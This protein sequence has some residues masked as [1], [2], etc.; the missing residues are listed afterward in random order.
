MSRKNL[1]LLDK[2][3]PIWIGLTMVFGVMLGKFA[4]KV[5]EIIDSVKIDTVSVPI[6]IGLLWM[7]YPVLAKVNYEKIPQVTRDWKVFTYSIILNWAVG[8]F[9]MYGLAKLFLS[10]YPEYQIG[11]II[12]GIARCIAMVLIWNLLAEGDNE[13]AAILVALNSV[14]QIFLYSVYA[15]FLI[16]THINITMWDIAKNVLIYLGIPLLA[17]FL[18]RF[19]LIRVKDQEWYNNK[20]MPK[21]S[22]TAMIGLLFTIVV[23]FAMQGETIVDNP[24]DILII[25]VP[26][27]LYFLIMFLASIFS[28][29]LLGFKYKDS[30]TISFTAASNNFELAIAVAVGLFTITSKQALATTVGPLI[31]VPVL[32]SLVYFAKWSK[33]WLFK[34]KDVLNKSK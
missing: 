25:A 7:M 22:P 8:P 1:G 23:M 21:L 11:L 26:L 10:N 29:K 32:L 20:F 28:S 34:E 31:E 18:T 13:K 9:L 30:V 16:G 2:Y 15:Y 14:M 6:A 19:I 33:S 17:G 3:L 27:T 4:P 5:A 24:L 12:V